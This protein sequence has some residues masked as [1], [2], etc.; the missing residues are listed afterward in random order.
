MQTRTEGF[1]LPRPSYSSNAGRRRGHHDSEFDIIVIG[2]CNP[3]I[4]LRGDN[5]RPEF[6]QH[7]KLVPDAA[8]VIG[9]SG[10]ITACA[11]A[12][13]GLR[14]RFI[15]ATG[16]DLFGRYMLEQL[17]DWGIDTT[18]CPVL[19]DVGTGFSVVLSEGAD[20]AILTHR[21]TIDGLR[22]E[23]LPLGELVRAPHVHIG[24]Y[25]LQPGLAAQ[26]PE[27]TSHL[28]ANGVTVSVD[29]NWDPAGNWDNGLL[30]LLSSVDIFLP[31]AAEARALTGLTATAAAAL[32]LA[33]N[34][35]LVVVKDGAE[36]CIAAEHGAISSQPGFAVDCVDTTGAG[37]AFDSGFLRGWL[38][39][40]P[41][42]DCLT[43]GC[44]AG[45]LSTRSIGA[46]G[47]LATLEE[48]KATVEAGAVKT[49]TP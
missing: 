8:L 1:D 43:Y 46:T 42:A 28:R 12:R 29:P 3:D 36:G 15:G 45:A 24:S 6:G 27:L 37:D 10:S 47:S 44:S 16:N 9:G 5:I 33:Q 49:G 13:L 39:G 19:D 20:R 34:G 21:G 7:E 23:M 38:D 48:L 40:L 30:S 17:R 32:Q 18:L 22:L 31:N 2:D 25:F 11:C 41:L 4:V 35:N 26:L 14:A